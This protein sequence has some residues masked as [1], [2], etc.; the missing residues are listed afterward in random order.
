M[1]ELRAFSL[2]SF[3]F[4]LAMIFMACPSSNKPLDPIDL[5]NNNQQDTLELGIDCGGPCPQCFPI[6][7]ERELLIRNTAIVDDSSAISGVL[8]FGHIIKRLAVSESQSLELISSLINSWSDTVLVNGIKVAPRL[9]T[10]ETIIDLWRGIDTSAVSDDELIKFDSNKTPF[11]LLSINSRFDLVDFNKGKVGEGRLTYGLT[12]GTS[13]FTLIFECNLE[14]NSEKDRIAWI[15]RWHQLSRMELTSQEYLDTLEVIVRTFSKSADQLSQLRT[16]EFLSGSQWE[17]R[18]YNILADG[19]FHEVTRK[20]NPTSELQGDTLLLSYID[21]HSSEITTGTI[22]EEFEGRKLLAGNTLYGGS[23][24]WQVPGASAVQQKSLDEMT[25]N[26]CV[27]CHGGLVPGTG[28][29]HIKPRREGQQSR[30]SGFMIGDLEN[31]VLAIRNILGLPERPGELFEKS[32]VQILEV[33]R[34]DSIRMM[35]DKFKNVTRVH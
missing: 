25:F 20:A 3:F 8:S 5:C 4:A 2:W 1:K 11:R 14:G 18:E 35:L 26:S 6:D 16:N 13:Q 21:Q 24:K 30:L 15:K 32:D 29:T 27:G 23:F 7:P 28:F 12:S 34:I 22:K 31:R 33:Q 19:L 10:R 9:N 17:F